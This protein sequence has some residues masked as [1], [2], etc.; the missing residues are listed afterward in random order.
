MSSQETDHVSPTSLRS[1]FSFYRDPDHHFAISELSTAMRSRNGLNALSCSA[2]I[3]RMSAGPQQAAAAS[4][5]LSVAIS[6][7][8]AAAR[9]I[10]ITSASCRAD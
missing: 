7:A 4:L 6:T 3:S 9:S 5:C 2:S 10:I 1:E 8:A